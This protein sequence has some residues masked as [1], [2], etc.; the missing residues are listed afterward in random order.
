MSMCNLDCIAQ[1]RLVF[2]RFIINNTAAHGY[3]ID[4]DLFDNYLAI[5]SQANSIKTSILQG[6]EANKINPVRIERLKMNHYSI[7]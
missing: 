7:E 5:S 1:Y 6:F 4:D 2:H 3:V